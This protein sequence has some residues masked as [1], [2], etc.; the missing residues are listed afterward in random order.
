MKALALI[1]GGLDS[2]LAAR[3]IQEQDIEVIAAY[4][5]FPFC[6]RKQEN[7]S[8]CP[9]KVRKA[10]SCLGLEVNMFDITD[11]F[12]EMLQHPRHGY[13]GEI[14][15]CIDC[16]ILMLRTAKKYMRQFNAS[17][18]VTGEVLGQ[19]PMSQ[20]RKALSIIEKESGLEGFLVRPLSA[21]LLPETVPEK[22]GW[23]N[24]DLLMNMNGRSRRPQVALARK[25]Q[26]NDYATPAGG[27]LLT[28]AQFANRVK[29]LIKHGDLTRANIALLNMGRHFRLS[30]KLKLVVGRDEP[31][32]GRLFDVAMPGD[33]IF[34]PPEHVAG[35]TALLRG[36]C[37]DAL[38]RLA[39][40]MVSRYF[41]LNG[42]LSAE[43]VYRIFPESQEHC[44]EVQV[45]RDDELGRWRI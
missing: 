4:F 11:E 27:C 22:Q 36:V 6:S 35:A 2:V 39:A 7:G 44:L 19:R 18:V 40:A 13:G 24:R 38:I 20:H 30:D 45:M 41:D 33:H 42:Q 29:D 12:I 3:L 31:E 1:S 43:V 5:T 26:I 28:D 15:P 37:S 17:F 25:F 32:A 16:K 10:A 34:Q 9:D 14:N 8:V 21:R 23:L